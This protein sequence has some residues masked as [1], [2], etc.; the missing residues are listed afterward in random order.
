LYA[1]IFKITGKPAAILDLGCGI[2][3]F[4]IPLM[5]LLQRNPKPDY[6]LNYYAC[7]LSENEIETLNL[8]FEYLQAQN[9]S[10]TG[11]AG[12]LDLVQW[13][14]LSHLEKADICFLFKMTDVLDQGK[15]HKMTELVI[16]KVPA[17]YV[18]LSFPTQTMGGKKMNVPQRN[19]VEWMCRRLGYSFKVLE[20]QTEIF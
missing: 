5:N 17:R 12:I 16:Q 14:K 11:T 13:A 8:F 7:D 20:F 1:K 3:P 4:S 9:P 18:V 19:W 2:N 15:G 10:F 6:Q